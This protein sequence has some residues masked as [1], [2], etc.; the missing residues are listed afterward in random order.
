MDLLSENTRSPGDCVTI[1]GTSNSLKNCCESHLTTQPKIPGLAM[2]AIR[3]FRRSTLIATH[4]DMDMA[5]PW[6]PGSRMDAL[7][8]IH[9][10]LIALLVFFQPDAGPAVA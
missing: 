7:I 5:W 6:F 3:A 8:M 1:T 10:K 4:L 2:S 9:G